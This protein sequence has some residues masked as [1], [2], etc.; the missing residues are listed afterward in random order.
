M[1][2]FFAASRRISALL[3]IFEVAACSTVD[4]DG[5]TADGIYDPFE[6]QNR[7]VHEFN[8]NVD[9]ALLRPTAV[10]YSSVIPDD[11]EDRIVN[12]SRNLQSP[13]IV[14][15]SLLQG[16]VPGAGLGV[17]RF[18]VN[19]VLGLAG[20]FD[21]ATDF[22]IPQHETDFGETL[23]VWGVGEGAYIELPLLGPS[24][25]RDTT[26]LLVDFFTNPLSYVGLDGPA[27]YVSLGAGVARGMSSRGRY[28][29][30]VDG[31][32]YGS[33]DSY[34]QARLIATQNRRF[35][36][37]QEDASAEIDPFALDTEGF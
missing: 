37:G 11:I 1:A 21:A 33:A 16:D 32:L 27:S 31:V 34:S 4:G 15:N 29:D 28:V 2:R 18:A 14:V 6:T 13:S 5:M 3:L 36:L 30:S 24:N 25:Q 12:F 9:Q 17:V 19:S 7:R 22:G 20:L 8:R 35:E 26:G 10:G 23:H